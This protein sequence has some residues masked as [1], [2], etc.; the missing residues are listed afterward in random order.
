MVTVLTIDAS[1]LTSITRLDCTQQTKRTRS[2][3][4]RPD[5]LEAVVKHYTVRG[6]IVSQ[7]D[8]FICLTPEGAQSDCL[9]TMEM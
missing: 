6:W 3:L 9:V 7:C 2:I 5:L 1:V 8:T 4:V